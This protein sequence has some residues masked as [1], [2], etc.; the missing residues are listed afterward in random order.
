M[1]KVKLH[2][3]AAGIKFIFNGQLIKLFPVPVLTTVQGLFC[4]KPPCK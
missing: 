1:L 3:P 4:G 2:F